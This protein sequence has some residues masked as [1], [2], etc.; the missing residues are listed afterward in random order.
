MTGIRPSQKRFNDFCDEFTDTGICPDH[1]L[2]T[3]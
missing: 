1:V 3:S 2:K